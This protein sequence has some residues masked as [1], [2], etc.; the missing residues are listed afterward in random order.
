MH[1]T[2]FP[3]IYPPRPLGAI[4]PATLANYSGYVAQYKFNDIRILI[5]IDARGKASLLSRKREPLLSYEL[6]RNARDSLAK[7][8]LPR[9]SLHLLDGGLMRTSDF[10]GGVHP[11]VLW[12]VLMLKSEYL[13]GTTYAERYARLRAICGNP[14]ARERESGARLALRVGPELWLCDSYSSDFASLFASTL[15]QD[16]LEGLVMKDP[17][18]KLEIGASEENNGAW[19][20]RVRKTNARHVF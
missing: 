17:N 18:G 5:Q 10:P 20:I 8:K 14:R 4:S 11:I 9:G 19:Q 16:A 15:E 3:A 13:V 6:T 7:L 2:Q 1:V 12:D